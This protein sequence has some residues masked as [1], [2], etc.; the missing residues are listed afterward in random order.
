MTPIRT[1][2]PQVVLVF[3]LVHGTV[4]GAE[5]SQPPVE[6]P[7]RVEARAL[8]SA[9]KFAEADAIYSSL[10]KKNRDDA[11]L[12]LD[13]G[14]NLYLLAS[15][16]DDARK[17]VKLRKRSRQLLLR[18]QELGRQ[19]AIIEM[20]LNAV[21]PDGKEVPGREFSPL[22]E[23]DDAMRR[24]ER[25]FAK[26]DMAGAIA[27]YQRA[28]ELDPENYQATLYI[29]DVHFNR[30]ELDLAMEWFRKAVRL[31]P[32]IETAH[33]YWGD[34]A[35]KA[36]RAA[37]A[38]QHYID[39]VVAEPYSRAPREMLERF[40]RNAGLTWRGREV[41]LPNSPVSLRGGEVHIEIDPS[42]ADALAL[43]HGLACA[44]WRKEEFPKHYAAAQPRRSLREEMHALELMRK[45]AAELKQADP[46]SVS[47][48]E[49]G[50]AT[51]DAV[52]A[53]DLLAPFVFFERG[54]REIAQDYATYRILSRDRLARYIA[55]FWCGLPPPKHDDEPSAQAEPGGE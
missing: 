23:A 32:D 48:W 51:L 33:R 36:G 12:H 14:Y 50:L 16:L 4:F 26:N 11:Q 7:R 42:N 41:D 40:S 8:S 10:L 46:A 15:T 5:P 31:N 47:R 20:C 29:G 3:A 6:D 38:L 35:R 9:H 22:K 1:L 17:A 43:I 19:D 52:I 45:T 49:R 54:D 55:E 28:R 44:H 37:E 13:A 34:A 21:Q 53:A 2:L 24:G 18:A 30:G 39:A 27:A 25:A